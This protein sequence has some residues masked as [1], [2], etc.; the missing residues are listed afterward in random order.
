MS[1]TKLVSSFPPN[2]WILWVGAGISYPGPSSLPLAIP[3]TSFALRECCGETTAARIL[4]MWDEANQVVGS[5]SNPAPL[6]KVPRLESVLGDVDDVRA[7]SVNPEFDFLRGFRSFTSTP[8]NLNH[9]YLADLLRRGAIVVTTNFDACIENAYRW[10]TRGADSLVLDS[11]L[12]TPFYRPQNGSAGRVWHIHGTAEHIPSLGATIRAVKEGLPSG[13]INWL[14]GALGSSALVIFLGY[15]AGDSFDVNLYFGGKGDSQFTNSAACFVQHYGASAPPGARLLLR[16]FGKKT[17]TTEDT[18]EVIK[19]LSGGRLLSPPPSPAMAWEGAFLRDA[20][21][22]ARSE[23]RDYLVCKLA[24]TLGVNVGLLDEGAYDNALRRENL[25]HGPD[26]HRT[27]AF[28][29]RVR[30]Q[31]AQEKQHDLKSKR[32]STALLGYYYS[33]GSVRRALK[34]A[35]TLDEVFDDAR[36]GSVELGWNTY[37]SMSAHCRAELDKYLFNP[38]TRGVS[39]SNRLEIESLVELTDLL[40]RVPLRNV[41]YLNQVA[42]ALRFNFLFKALLS[43]VKDEQTI[44]QVL[45]L[46]GEGAS[47]AGFISTYR[48]VAIMHLL[49]YKFH[50]VGGLADA[51]IYIA[52]SLRLAEVVG[53]VPSIKRARKLRAYFRLLSLIR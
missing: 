24:F 8:F 20:I 38:F 11:A 36:R 25:F 44:E 15:G 45:S 26:F 19:F 34:Y 40:S 21:M 43:G 30:G 39:A 52:K 3:L 12:G 16:P 42:T 10:L 33:Q 9:L 37:T 51:S 27:L 13:F 32:G 47:V 2:R 7:E 48:D 4:G 31:S 22:S 1:L 17:V 5:P 46:Y 6:G 50:R 53:D 18:T 49:L 14:D 35:K 29:C 23:A 28:V 41:R